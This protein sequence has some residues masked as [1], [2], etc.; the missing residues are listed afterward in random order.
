MA[1]VNEV[2]ARNSGETPPSIYERIKGELT[3][4]LGVAE[5]CPEPYRV[6]AFRVLLEEALRRIAAHEVPAAIAA[7]IPN[8]PSAPGPRPTTLPELVKTTQARTG[9][10]FVLVCGHWLETIGGK[11]E[12]FESADLLQAFAT[13]RYGAKNPYDAISKAKRDGLLIDSHGTM[14]LSNTGIAQLEVLLGRST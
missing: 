8:G 14:R 13:V 5:S 1:Q 12:G 11:P 9:S 7:R 3:P 6:T 2:H 4:I 10:D